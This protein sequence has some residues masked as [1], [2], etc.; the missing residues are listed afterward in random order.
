MPRCHTNKVAVSKYPKIL[1]ALQVSCNKNGGGDTGGGA[2]E[3]QD[4]THTKLHCQNNQG[5][6]Q[7]FNNLKKLG[8]GGGGV[9]VE[10]QD[11]TLTKLH[12][13][14]NQRALQVLHN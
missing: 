2:G 3:C 12:C 5:A 7:V 11:V 13:Q 9:R 14:N 1:R 6:L 4:V 8:G 10:C